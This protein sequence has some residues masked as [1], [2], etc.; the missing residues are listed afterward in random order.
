MPVLSSRK[1]ASG[2]WF[3]DTF[4]G[5]HVVQILLYASRFIP[6]LTIPVGKFAAWLANA[7]SV[8]VDDNYKI[9]NVNCR[10]RTAALLLIACI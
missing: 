1:L 7:Q 5:Y 6:S 10:V 2:N 3:W 4:C 8:A 9:F